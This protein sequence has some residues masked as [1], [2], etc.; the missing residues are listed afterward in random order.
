V[1]GGDGLV[2]VGYINATGIDLGAVKVA[3]DLDK[4]VA[5]NGVGTKPGIGSLSVQSLGVK[6]ITTGALNLESD[7]TGR[8]GALNVRGNVFEAFVKASGS[9]GAVRIGGSLI[10]GAAAYSGRISSGGNLGAVKVGHD[11]LGGVGLESGSISSSNLASLTIGG[12]LRGG[13]GIGSGD[14]D[15]R[16]CGSVKIT[17]DVV[18]GTGAGDYSGFIASDNLASVAV[19]GSLIGGSRR[20]NGAIEVVGR[21]GPVKIGGDLMGG[22][23][24]NSG[25]IEGY[26]DFS[27]VTIGGSL[28]GGSNSYSGAIF[29][30]TRLGPVKIGKDIQGGTA[31]YSGYI[32]GAR[33]AS[34]TVGGSIF[35]GPDNQGRDHDGWICAEKDFGRVVVKGSIV[36]NNVNSVLISAG[37]A[38]KPTATSD[39]AIRSIFV[40]KDITLTEIRGGYN[41]AQTF[42]DNNAQIGGITVNGAYSFNRISSGASPGADGVPG[43]SDDTFPGTISKIGRIVLNG[44]IAGAGPLFAID[45]GKIVSLFIDGTREPLTNGADSLSFAVGTMPVFDVR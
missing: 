9:M 25:S 4:I 27:S 17:G 7:I 18:G 37:G 38:V 31:S 26:N 2:N 8:L 41:S 14:I 10:G 11:I 45:S 33:I 28:V 39:V 35:A 43:T 1:T 34:V 19:G 6:G 30:V 20:F 24:D 29:S 12:S 44:T 23:G 3:G 36:G 32:T 42:V 13:S 40:G 5:G 22:A 21:A 15:C 16:N